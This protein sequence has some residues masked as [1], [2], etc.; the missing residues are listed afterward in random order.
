ME[1]YPT[2]GKAKCFVSK[3][4]VDDLSV[5]F[6]LS[7]HDNLLSGRT[8]KICASYLFFSVHRCRVLRER[9]PSSVF[10]LSLSLLARPVAGSGGTGWNPPQNKQEKLKCSAE[11]SEWLV[12]RAAW[13]FLFSPLCS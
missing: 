4:G 12:S 10:S 3:C 2:R 1:I 5:V 13:Q 6:L 11:D 7:A 9:G 8:I